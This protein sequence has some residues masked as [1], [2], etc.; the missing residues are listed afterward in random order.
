MWAVRP[1][2]VPLG[3][4]HIADESISVNSSCWTIKQRFCMLP[5][6]VL[7]A[8]LVLVWLGICANQRKVFPAMGLVHFP[9]LAAFISAYNAGLIPFFLHFLISASLRLV[10]SKLLALHPL[11]EPD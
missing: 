2:A 6:E 1:M 5:E 4:R 7:C 8:T 9:F 3:K 10:M 11:L